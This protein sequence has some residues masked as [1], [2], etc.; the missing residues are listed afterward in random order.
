MASK[1]PNQPPPEDLPSSDPDAAR[2]QIAFRP[3]EVSHDHYEQQVVDKRVDDEVDMTP[4]IDVTFL[5]LIF[6]MI[7]AAFALQSAL[8]VPPVQD[9][10]AAAS[11]TVEDVEKDSILI[12]IDGDNVFW[13]GAPLWNEEQ[14]APS[15][16]EMREKVRQAREGKG[17]KFGAGPAKVV[18]QAHGDATH[19]FVVAALD[20]GVSAQAEEIQL[21]KYE[22]EDL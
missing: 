14:R 10:E 7:T 2:S 21:A 15:K 12:R 20:A 18:V 5:L 1:P 11:Q 9:D 22:D 8:L 4:M 6:F 19:E 16:Q 17:G 13:I 3:D